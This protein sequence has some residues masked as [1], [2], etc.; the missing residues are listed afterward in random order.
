MLDLRAQYAAIRDEIRAA[1]EEVLAAQQFI[2]G[3]QVAALEKELAEFCGARL[4]VGVASG[5]DA[6]LLALHA[7]GVRAGDEVIVPAFSYIATADVCGLLGARPV[8]ADIVPETFNIDPSKI[9]AV[10][11][12]RTR[13]IVPVHLYGHA[14]DMDAVLEIGKRRNLPVIEDNAQAIGARYHGRRTGT[15][16]PL[17]CF[18]FFPTKNLGGYG[19]GGMIVTDSEELAAR[20]R[21]LRMHG[22][23]AD[24]Y[25]S[26][27]QGW[28]SR[29]DEMQAAI[30]RVKLRHLPRWQ[31]ARQGHAARYAEL[32]RA[33]AGVT[34][35]P[36]AAGC[37]HVYHQYTIRIA[38]GR[39]RRDR[40]Q[41]LLA[42]RG[43]A[44]TVYYPVPLHLQPMYAAL[45]QRAGDFPE[46]ER[47]AAE[48]LSLPIYP[49][50][51]PEQLQHVA[52][53]LAGAM[54]A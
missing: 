23:R 26:E 33:I 5:T 18:S 21:S 38:G 9:A 44:S 39:E 51:S 45:G 29:L 52:I 25:I 14:A 3:R 31:A 16:A 43:V 10:I 7:V 24:K 8:F 41:K 2:L 1:L 53:S 35:P 27:E 11:S 46:G 22:T 15:L 19:D 42:E 49:E 28:N 47:A 50:L 6:L 54:A 20:L 40:A 36:S 4:A 34:P 48:V 30:L 12:P 13:A 37:E 32:L 17:A